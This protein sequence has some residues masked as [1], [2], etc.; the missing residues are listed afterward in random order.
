MLLEDKNAV[1]YGGRSDRWCARPAFAREGAAVV[2]AGRNREL[3]DRGGRWRPADNN[4]SQ[5]WAR[6]TASA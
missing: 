4:I 1:I 6:W 3:A 5:S 2:L